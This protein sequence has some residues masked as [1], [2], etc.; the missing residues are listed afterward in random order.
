LVWFFVVPIPIYETSQTLQVLDRTTVA[1][2][3]GEQALNHIRPGEAALLN[4]KRDTSSQPGTIPAIVMRV[5]G[6]G[7]S[8]Q[9]ELYAMLDQFNSTG[10]LTNGT[11]LSVE[12]EIEQ[13]PLSTLVLRA[14]GHLVDTPQLSQNPSSLNEYSQYR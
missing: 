12:V 6:T 1:A 5:P 9:V 10:E 14:S 11:V 4:L 3:F 13:V 7:R 2:E 8:T